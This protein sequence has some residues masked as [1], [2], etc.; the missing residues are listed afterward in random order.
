MHGPPDGGGGGGS[1]IGMVLGGGGS[2][3]SAGGGGGGGGAPRL[4]AAGGASA[5]GRSGGG[6]AERKDNTSPLAAACGRDAEREASGAATTDR[7][8]AA[9]AACSGERHGTAHGAHGGGLTRNG[10]ARARARVGWQRLFLYYSLSL[11]SSQQT[12][13]APASR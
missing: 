5:A 8:F 7:P 9:R 11:Y 10:G 1:D 6:S 3:K 4:S 12:I 13:I 2:A